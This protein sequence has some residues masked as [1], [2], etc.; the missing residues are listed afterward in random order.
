MRSRELARFR[1]AAKEMKLVAASPDQPISQL[2]GGNQQKAVLARSLM[3]ASR[4]IV[5]DE[6]TQGVD[7]RAR[8]DIYHIL[9]REASSGTALLISSSDSA[10]LAGLCDRVYVLSRGRVVAELAGEEVEEDRIV[11]SFVRAGGRDGNPASS[12]RPETSTLPARS[13]RRQRWA[14]LGAT[15]LTT[16]T[17]VAPLINIPDATG[18][19]ASGVLTVV[20][21]IAYT[22]ISRKGSTRGPGASGHE[23]VAVIPR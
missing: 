9:R 17:N 4:L 15:F 13:G 8:L 23:P 2:S 3:R 7:A 18:Q 16:L 1:P 22:V 20:A 10:E 11:D 5:V 12:Q 21:V 14:L 19:I 6:P